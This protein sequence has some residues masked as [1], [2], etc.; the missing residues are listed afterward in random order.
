MADPHPEPDDARSSHSVTEPLLRWQAGDD[1]AQ[2]D[3]QRRLR[4]LQLELIRFVR[5]N[6]DQGLATV[7]ESEAIV[8]K[9]LCSF[10]MGTR[11]GGFPDLGGRENVRKLLFDMVGKA[12]RHEIRHN[13]RGRRDSGREIH[14]PAV[15]EQLPA[16]STNDAFAPSCDEEA[17]ELR[18]AAQEF[19]ESLQKRV[20]LVH[21][22]A[23]DI[24]ELLLQ[25]WSSGDIA[26]NLDMG[27]RNVQKIIKGMSDAWYGGD[28]IERGADISRAPW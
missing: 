5:R 4:G 18:L 28:S 27:Q 9:A 8:N 21:E 7:I 6:R 16:V 3:L 26:R 11:M 10:L 15:L 22:R 25:G 17:L 19:L 2:F 12:L 13:Q 23:M 24:L 14:D 20:R 1:S